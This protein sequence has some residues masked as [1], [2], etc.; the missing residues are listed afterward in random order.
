MQRNWTKD[1]LIAAFYLYCLTPFGRLHRGNPDIIALA[2]KLNR[3][4]SAL[5][6]KMCNFASFDP[7]H[8]NRNIKGLVNAAKSDRII[9]EEYH[10]NWDGLIDAYQ[11]IQERL[12]LQ[13]IEPK[14]SESL[15]LPQ[16]TET[17]A[18]VRIRLAQGFFRR[19]V[20]ANYNH[21]CAICRI[22]HPELLNASHIVPWSVDS[23]KRA[24]PQNGLS[25]C[26]LHD[27]AFDRGLITFDE[28]YRLML[29]RTIRKMEKIDM[30]K[31]GFLDR[32]GQPLF[33]PDKFAPLPEA[34]TYHR[35]H[36]FRK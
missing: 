27:R 1:E 7:F 23:A 15:I 6:M 14:V 9:W 25:L 19:S 24:D 36:L 28:H 4:P 26:A 18:T 8:Q 22:E 30:Y 21:H 29:S 34:L 33:L 13:E 17:T 35:T 20:L 11:Q 5:A 3:T 2:K 10:R 12:N 32:E 31:V 16:E